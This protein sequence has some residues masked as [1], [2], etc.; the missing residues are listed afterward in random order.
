ML[1]CVNLAQTDLKTCKL[2]ETIPKPCKLSKTSFENHVSKYYNVKIL[3]KRIIKHVRLSSNEKILLN[4]ILK[5][6][7]ISD[8][9]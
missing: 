1:F 8:I 7:R 5:L 9:I 3:P 6:V 2:S 4:C